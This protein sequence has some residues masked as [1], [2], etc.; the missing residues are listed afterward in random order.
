MSK[1]PNIAVADCRLS[2]KMAAIVDRMTSADY[3]AQKTV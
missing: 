3:K 2:G 1:R